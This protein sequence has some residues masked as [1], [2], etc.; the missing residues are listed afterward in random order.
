MRAAQFV[1]EVRQGQQRLIHGGVAD[2]SLE[3]TTSNT[4]YVHAGFRRGARYSVQGPSLAHSR[5]AGLQQRAAKAL[6]H[7]EADDAAEV[8][9]T[10]DELVDATRTRGGSSVMHQ[11]GLQS[12]GCLTIKGCHPNARKG[13]RSSTRGYSR[14]GVVRRACRA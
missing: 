14:M 13:A 6:V 2:V 12:T 9:L 11:V 4:Q 1:E 5:L 10:S 7:G 3:L 8:C